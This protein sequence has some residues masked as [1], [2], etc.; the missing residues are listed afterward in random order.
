MNATMN[1][2]LQITDDLAKTT[3]LAQKDKSMVLGIQT[4]ETGVFG[5]IN[6]Y[7]NSIFT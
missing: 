6:R 4:I 7:F 5:G 2:M 3:E 1:G